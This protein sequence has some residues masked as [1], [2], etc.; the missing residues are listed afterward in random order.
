MKPRIG[1]FITVHAATDTHAMK[2]EGFGCVFDLLDSEIRVLQ[3]GGGESDK[4]IRGG[5]TNL[6]QSFVLNS[7]HFGGRITLGMVLV[8]I[9]AKRSDINALRVHG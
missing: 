7:D 1:K 3:G 8:W 9:D 2:S 4:S 6:D 5:S